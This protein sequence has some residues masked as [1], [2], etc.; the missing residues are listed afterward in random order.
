MAEVK[1]DNITKVYPNGFQAVTDLSLEL[2]DGEFLV[3]VGPSGCGKSTALRMIAGLEEISSGD[4]YVGDRNVTDVQP[5]D[6]DIAMVFQ[7]Y[8]LYPGMTVGANMAFALKQQGIPKEERMKRVQEAARILD[9]EE[10][11]ERK[12]KNLSGGQRQRVAIARALLKNA[13]IL[14][15]DEATSALDNESER[16]VQKGLD[17]L[18]QGRTTLVV[19]HRLSTI[20]NADR[21][22]VMKKGQVVEQGTHSELIANESHYSKL[23]QLHLS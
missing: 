4:L 20:E 3:L 6:R 12:P 17:T 11:L 14:I 9:L 13:P 5:K 19:A 23:Q 15:L 10:Y 22:V 16:K 8:A 7:N 2:E 21:I 18:M 1:L